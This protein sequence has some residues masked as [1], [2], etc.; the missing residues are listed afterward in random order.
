[1]WNIYAIIVGIFK[2]PTITEMTHSVRPYSIYFTRLF[3]ATIIDAF[4]LI[5]ICTSL[6]F[7]YK[8]AMCVYLYGIGG[9]LLKGI[10][11]LTPFMFLQNA[12]ILS[13]RLYRTILILSPFVLFVLWYV[14]LILFQIESLYVDV[15]FGYISRFPH[16][17]VQIFS[18]LLICIF[19]LVRV[20][21]KLRVQGNAA[22]IWKVTVGNSRFKLCPGRWF[23]FCSAF[24]L[25]LVL[26]RQRS[27]FYSGTT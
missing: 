6:S 7:D 8:S 19:T 23:L 17:I 14:W 26:G 16:F 2:L 18:I 3:L 10:I 9:L 22:E 20:N 25:H 24:Y 21:R 12:S 13:S 15:S 27:A 4:I 1:M 5:L 11:F